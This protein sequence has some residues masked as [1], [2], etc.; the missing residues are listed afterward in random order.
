MTSN[1]AIGLG[2]GLGSLDKEKSGE[3]FMIKNGDVPSFGGVEGLALLDPELE[4]E[5]LRGLT[6]NC[7][8]K[9]SGMSVTY[10]SNTTMPNRT[11]PEIRTIIRADVLVRV[12]TGELGWTTRASR[13]SWR[14]CA[15]LG[16]E[17]SGRRKTSV[18]C[19]KTAFLD[20]ALSIEYET[21]IP[22]RIRQCVRDQD[23]FEIG[24][25][26]G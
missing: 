15:L 12:S 21:R 24:W 26:Y 3:R 11:T 16:C 4:G 6:D 10:G 20:G 19:R 2:P 7:W 14:C 23:G 18:G 13:R 17:R 1:C 5:A 8:G 25:R 9:T 22:N